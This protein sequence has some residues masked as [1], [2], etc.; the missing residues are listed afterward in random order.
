MSFCTDVKNEICA[1]KATSRCCKRAECAGLYLG[2][3]RKKDGTLT[4]KTSNTEVA[5]IAQKCFELQFG[6]CTVTASDSGSLLSVNTV[7]PISNAMLADISD[8]YEKECCRKA[9]IKGAFL[10]CGQITNPGSNYRLDFN[11]RAKESA[12][13]V[14]DVLNLAG[15]HPKLSI[16]SNGYAT[17][18]FKNINDIEDITAYMDATIST[19]GMLEI[20]VEKDY[21]NH[22]NRTV[23]FE[24]ANFV[25][26]FS[27]VNAQIAAINKLISSGIFPNIDPKLKE[28]AKLRL[29][30]PESSLTVLSELSG[31]NRSTL[32][33]RFN[34]IIK[35]AEN[36]GE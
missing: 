34:E 36:A 27:A 23:N 8:I 22:L 35:L 20:M 25:R 11:L 17:V 6:R 15:F 18:Y 33:K 14:Y 26:S 7:L 28:V 16:K 3:K 10:A 4:F 1:H 21:K 31:I 29:D 30:N 12:E 13:L 19:L 24:T 5:H 32:S 2:A 9:F